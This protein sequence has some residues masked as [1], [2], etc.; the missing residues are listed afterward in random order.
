M[1]TADRRS[2]AAHAALAAVLL[3]ALAPLPLAALEQTETIRRTFT[4]AEVGQQRTL[5]VENL[6]GAIEIEAGGG[7]TVELTLTQT[8][9]ARKEEDLARARRE[10]T[11]QVTEEPGRLE[12]IQD[13]PW[14]CKE[15]ARNRRGGCCCGDEPSDGRRYDVRFDWKLRV[16]R[17]LDLEV[18]SVNEGAIRIA[19]VAGRLEVFHV[20][21]D[22]RLE[23]VGGVVDANTVNGG[24]EVDFA[25]LPTGDCGFSTVNG[26]I[27]LAFPKGLGAE[28]SFA[29]MNGEVYTDFPFVAGK[30]RPTSARSQAGGRRHFE[31]GG[32][33]AAT[34][35]GGGIGLAC[36]TLNGDITIRERS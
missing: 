18:S 11:L 32:K 16:P 22:V 25:A 21:D 14:R 24:L 29:T 4:L 19:G 34:I 30:L 28:L 5:V 10:V 1:R 15:R 31:V 9:E 26:D 35:G 23:R 8:F 3:V 17:T 27:D 12:L 20:N 13:G 33:S 6:S 2:P 36:R 7:D